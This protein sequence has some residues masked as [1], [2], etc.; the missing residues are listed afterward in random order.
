M[1]VK[2]P[3]VALTRNTLQSDKNLFF[4]AGVDDFQT[5]V[6]NYCQN[7]FFKLDFP[8]GGVHSSVYLF[9]LKRMLDICYQCIQI[10]IYVWYLYFLAPLQHLCRDRL[11]QL[12]AQYGFEGCAGNRRG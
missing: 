6:C 8:L 1:G 5:K 3:I 12:L 2:T 10:L 11:V 7:M 4:E 9:F